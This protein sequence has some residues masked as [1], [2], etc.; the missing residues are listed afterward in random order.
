MEAELRPPRRRLRI[1]E[2]YEAPLPLDTRLRAQLIN[3][4]VLVRDP[5]HI[6]RI[7]SQGFFGKGILSRSRPDFTGCSNHS[8]LQGGASVTSHTHDITAVCPQVSS[9]P[10]MTEYLQLSLEETFFLVYG[11][12]CLSVYQ[13]QEPL[14]VVQLWR[15][16]CVIGPDFI[17]SYAA[18][19]HLRS[20][21]WVPKGGG[22]KYGAD[23]M[24]Y[25][26][27]P[28]FYHAS[29]SVVVQRAD[30][31]FRDCSER[32]FSW[33]SLAALSRIASSV[34][35]E[36]MLCYIIYPNNQSESELES[37]DCLRRLSVQEVVVNRWV[38]S[39]E[40]E[41]QDQL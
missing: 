22:A 10:L 28:P 39:K 6:R 26:K 30:G 4:H 18:Y 38:S 16:L 8:S 24:L 20:R 14:S 25:R 33:R 34:S 35:K 23:F 9:A 31:A 15:R 27:G 5:E 2:Q 32:H 29:Y 21:G 3:K 19:H 12:G 13:E 17:S 36:L 37:P 7:H 11:L 41:E 1:T 40:R